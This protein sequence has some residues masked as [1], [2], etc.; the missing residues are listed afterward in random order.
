M[1]RRC[2]ADMVNRACAGLAALFLIGSILGGCRSLPDTSGYTTA[3]IQVK[4][5]VATIGE[6]VQAELVSAIDA[7]AT[8]AD[9]ASVKRFEAAWAATV[10]SLDAM[11]VHAQSIEE[12]VDA[13]SEGAK[14]AIKVADSVKTL[15]DAAKVDAT[16]AVSGELVQLSTDTVAF[17]Y[18]EYSKYVAAKSLAGALDRFGPSMAKING[19]VQAQIKDAQ[20]LFVQQINAQVNRL[21]A[22]SAGYG[23]WI[24]Q[25]DKLNKQAETAVALLGRAISEG[26]DPNIAMAQKMIADTEIG[27]EA[28][29]PRLAEYE[30]KLSALRQRE[31]AG[32]SILGAA[33]NAIAAWG[34]THEQLAQ[35]VRDCKPV[36]V[37]SLIAAV[38]EIRTLTQRWREL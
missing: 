4:Q 29:A 36:S 31:K 15:V 16:T 34:T 26:D 23:A 8:A 22:D 27:R 12:I 10:G 7:K 1:K 3:T 24:K 28:I 9:H 17:V 30:A 2:L 5:A 33:A 35:A 37:E 13:G 11:V 38:V 14:S 18:G 25:N 21:E 20:R 32:R 6:V 19:L